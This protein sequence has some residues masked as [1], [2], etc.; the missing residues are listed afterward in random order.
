MKTILIFRTTSLLPTGAILE[1]RFSILR[2]P[3][4]P[5]ST[6]WHVP[7][8]DPRVWQPLVTVKSWSPTPEITATRST[9]IYN[10]KNLHFKPQSEEI[11]CVNE[12]VSP[13]C[14]VLGKY[15]FESETDINSL[16][17]ESGQQN[18]LN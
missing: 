7:C 15:R 1:F 17:Y 9:N 10:N 8:M 4:S 18:F 13:N 3:F 14:K 6:P 2:A 5:L 16:S 11:T 12:F